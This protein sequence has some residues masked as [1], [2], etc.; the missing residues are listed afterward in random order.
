MYFLSTSELSRKSCVNLHR[1]I[2]M[3]RLLPILIIILA[4]AWGSIG[5]NMNVFECNHQP[6]K[7]TTQIG[8]FDYG[9]RKQAAILSDAHNLYRI[10]NSR[11]QRIL[12]TFQ[13]ERTT[14]NGKLPIDN[15]CL[16]Y[17][18]FK[19]IFK[20]RNCFSTA[21]IPFVASCKYYILQRHIIR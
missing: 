9:Q 3:K 17:S 2:R 1:N 20:G 14:S 12:P 18:Y 8:C 11:P 4:C 6:I 7:K 21:S 5:K 10:C 15:S 19:L 13:A 16:L